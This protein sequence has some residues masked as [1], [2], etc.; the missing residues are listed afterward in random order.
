MKPAVFLD[1]DGTI[2]ENVHHLCD[3]ALVRLL[4]GAARAIQQLRSA[5]FS[6]IVVTNQ[7]VIGRGMLSVAGLE[8]IHEAMCRQLAADGA[9]LDGIYHCP[10][11]PAVEGE[12]AAVEHP[13]RKP[14]PGMLLRAARELD[15]DLARSWMIGDMLSDVLAGQNAGCCGTILLQD[16]AAQDAADAARAAASLVVRDLAEAAELILARTLKPTGSGER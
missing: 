3:P 14:G 15:L 7:S 5:G 2:I 6:A 11:A 4:P 12:R 8:Q 1:R 16:S 9:V 13:D 10:V